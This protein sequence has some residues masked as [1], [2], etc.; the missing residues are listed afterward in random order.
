MAEWLATARCNL[1]CVHCAA[2]A[3]EPWPHELDTGEAE[4]MLEQV[5]ELGVEQLCISGGEFT[6]RNDWQRLLAASL[7]RF[8]GVVLLTNGRLGQR[9]PQLLNG[10]AGLDRLTVLVSVDGPRGAH[11]AR[12]G[13]GSFELALELLRAPS[14]FAVELITAVD[15][16]N[17]ELLV[18]IARIGRECGA[19]GLN[20]QPCIP[21]GRMPLHECLDESEMRRLANAVHALQ[22]VHAPHMR[23]SPNHWFGYFHPMRAS[24]AWSGCPAGREQF[25]ILPDGQVTGCLVVPHWLCGS[26]RELRLP[27][28]W[29]GEKMRRV[30]GARPAGCRDCEGCPRGCEAMQSQLGRQF[31]FR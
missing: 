8:R 25:A 16:A 4:S 14:R 3:G 18:E 10:S 17:L 11:D 24:S 28:I 30:C 26:L 5:A 31:C 19:A 1:R 6:L 2:Q 12:R 7:A 29:Q 13:R 23:V 22:Q 9:M 27:D 15:R 20:V 21:L